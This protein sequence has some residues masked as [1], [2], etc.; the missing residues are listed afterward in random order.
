MVAP[1]IFGMITLHFFPGYTA[2][3]QPWVG[4]LANIT[5]YGVIAATLIGYFRSILEFGA[6]PMVVA[7]AAVAA[8]FGF[9]YLAGGGKD[10]LEDV[11]ALSTAQRN[12]AAGF[13]IATQDFEDPRVL[14]MLA[15]ANLLRRGTHFSGPTVITGLL[16]IGL[17]AGVARTRFAAVASLAALVVPSVL[18]A[19]LGW[20]EVQRVA[21]VSP[22]PRGVPALSLPNLALLTPELV[23]SAAAIA[24]VIAVQGAGVSQ[25]VENPDDRPISASRDMLAQGAANVASALFSGI[26]AGGSVGQTAL[27]V[28]VGAQSRWAGVLGGVWMLVFIVL[29]PQLVSQVP[30]AVLAALMIAD[31]SG[32]PERNRLSRSSIDLDYRRCRA[33]VDGGD[34]RRDPRLVRADGD[35]SR[36]LAVG[37][38][39]RCFVGERHQCARDG[40]A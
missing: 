2:S 39:V 29:A 5:L 37:G 27:N 17:A 26:P 14:V 32:G 4:K 3:V 6:G 28:S 40:A 20:E 24:V 7:V 16:A 35:W 34:V 8:A 33:V 38:V 21:D 23:L 18:V 15:L 25:S 13:I 36:R 10:H 9:G 1:L 30:M 31:D 19:M 22:I 12:T 11:G